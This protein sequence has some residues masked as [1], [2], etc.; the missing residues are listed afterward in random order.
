M[1]DQD[2]TLEPTEIRDLLLKALDGLAAGLID[3]PA[4]ARISAAVKRAGA[5]MATPPADRRRALAALAAELRQTDRTLAELLAR[6][7]PR[8]SPPR[9]S[10]PAM[11]N[12]RRA[13]RRRQVSLGAQP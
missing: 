13:R 2:A 5:L 4:A 3:K 7:R 10:T 1:N 12:S 8:R 9:T 6:P 11:T